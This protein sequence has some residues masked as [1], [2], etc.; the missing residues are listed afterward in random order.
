VSLEQ[1][2][3]RLAMD[4]LVA[5]DFSTHGLAV[6]EAARRLGEPLGAKI[7]VIHVVMPPAGFKSYGA[8]P[9]TDR[10]ETAAEIHEEHR[11][12]QEAA[13]AMRSEG[14]EATGL[15]VEGPPAKTLLEEAARLEVD[16]IIV[17]SH[18]R[19]ALFRALLGSVSS[20]VIRHATCPVL[21]VPV[22]REV[23]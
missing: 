21:V 18:G 3:D 4:L 19:G 11:L 16:M 5:T 14:L 13:A 22:T 9:R 7:W 6:L 23:G 2:R 17:G 20:G 1:T 10:R 8:G 15:L 12:V